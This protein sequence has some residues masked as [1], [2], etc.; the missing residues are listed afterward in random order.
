MRQLGLG[1]LG[2]IGGVLLAL[3]IHDL[4]ATAFLSN[5]TI[6]IGPGIVIGSL[7]P[8]LAVLGAVIAVLI[9]NRSLKRTSEKTP[10]E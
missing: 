8:V 4:L 9:Y 6:P 2:A 7:I 10:E 1:A 3:I 5:G